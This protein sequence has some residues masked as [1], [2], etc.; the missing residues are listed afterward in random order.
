MASFLVFVS[1]L[2]KFY[3]MD[4]IANMLTSLVNAQRAGK[5]RVAVPYS[6]FKHQLLQFLQ[7]Q[8]YIAKVRVQESP[9]PKLVVTLKYYEDEKPR[10]TGVKRLSSPGRRWYTGHTEV[11]FTYQGFGTVVISTSKGIIDEVTAR[12]EHIGGEIICAI[13]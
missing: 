1:L 7:E 10:I 4:V 8:G 13:W 12:K 2:G 6:N 9:R 3:A 5:K 11:P